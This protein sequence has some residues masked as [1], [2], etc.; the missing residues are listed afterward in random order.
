MQQRRQ[1]GEDRQGDTGV[2]ANARLTAYT[3]VVLLLPVVVVSLTGLIAPHLLPAHIAVGFLAVPPALL[4]LGSVGYRF[5]RYYQGEPRYR[6]AGTPVLGMRLLAPFLVLLTVV[7][8]GSGIELW[9]FGYRYGFAWL[10]IHHASAYLWLLVMA[11]HVVNYVRR[12]PRL[13]VADWQDQLRG[14]TTRRG[15][16]LGSLVLGAALAVALL[17]Y[18][19]PFT[20]QGG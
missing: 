1:D 14:A 16:V 20:A 2:E 15:L 18:P 17:P 8:F 13:A 7:V 10:P 9:L 4:K 11:V 6:A 19:S 3:A 5:A 12:A